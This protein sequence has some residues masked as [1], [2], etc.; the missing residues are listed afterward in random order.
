MY[1]FTTRLRHSYLHLLVSL[2]GQHQLRQDH[3]QVNWYMSENLRLEFNYGYGHLDRFGLNGNT[4][5][6]QSRIQLVF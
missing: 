3:S 1:G 4:H 5:I 2:L 6:F